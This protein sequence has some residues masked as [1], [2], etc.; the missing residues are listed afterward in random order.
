MPKSILDIMFWH[1]DKS[2]V[3][4]LTIWNKLHVAVIMVIKI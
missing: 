3:S 4:M 1:L 2:A